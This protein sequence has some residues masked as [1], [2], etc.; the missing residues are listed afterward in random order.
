MKLRQALMLL[1]VLLLTVSPVWAEPTPD[2]VIAAI[3]KLGGSVFADGE[4]AVWA[5]ILTDTNVNDAGLVHLKGLT[6]LRTLNLPK[7]KVAR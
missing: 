5:V 3:K 2:E 4:K 7:C 6:K 1:V